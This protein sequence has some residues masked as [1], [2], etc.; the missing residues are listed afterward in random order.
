MGK[1]LGEGFAS[2]L[3]CEPPHWTLTRLMVTL[4]PRATAA[5]PSSMG[6]SKLGGN[7]CWLIP[8]TIAAPS[9]DQSAVKGRL[10]R[11]I[12]TKSSPG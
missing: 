3:G 8:P 12:A 5:A 4:L 1:R 10:I 9:R 11:V 2:G 7:W 6:V